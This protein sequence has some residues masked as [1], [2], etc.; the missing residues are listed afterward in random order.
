MAAQAYLGEVNARDGGLL[1]LRALRFFHALRKRSLAKHSID[2]RNEIASKTAKIAFSGRIGMVAPRSLKALLRLLTPPKRLST[3]GATASAAKAP[4]DSEWVKLDTWPN[5]DSTWAYVLSEG[6]SAIEKARE[7]DRNAEEQG[8]TAPQPSEV[9][10]AYMLAFAFAA[11]RAADGKTSLSVLDFGGGLGLYSTVAR[12]SGIRAWITPFKSCLL[13]PKPE[14]L[15]DQVCASFQMS[16]N[17]RQPMISYLLKGPSNTSRIG[18]SSWQ[19]WRPAV[20][21]GCFSLA[22]WC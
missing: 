15:L 21:L 14:L 6:N 16:S 4:A 17:W 22:C 12:L 13:S 10:R 11:A 19:N 18:A 1:V 20:R 3:A 8:F 5:I 2:P 7:E 9:V